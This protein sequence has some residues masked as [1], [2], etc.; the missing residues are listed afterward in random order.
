MLFNLS[1]RSAFQ[2][3]PAT[4]L[5]VPQ[6]RS[7][8]RRIETEE[9]GT[10]SAEDWLSLSEIYLRARWKAEGDGCARRGTRPEA[11]AARRLR[12]PI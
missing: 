11:C 4:P 7:E 10:R 9:A 8:R 1:L 5:I 12:A 2:W 6:M 3:M